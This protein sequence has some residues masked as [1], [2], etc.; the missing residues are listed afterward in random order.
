MT[1]CVETW[2]YTHMY[3]LNILKLVENFEALLCQ[4]QAVKYE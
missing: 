2:N 3:L 1:K 4:K